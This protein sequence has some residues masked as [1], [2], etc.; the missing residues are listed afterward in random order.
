MRMHD[1]IGSRI[2]Y[3][4][5]KADSGTDYKA[6]AKYYGDK[7]CVVD[8]GDTGANINPLQIILDTQTMGNSAYAYSKAYDRH[9]GPFY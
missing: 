2:I 3:V 8:I 1:M 4:T 5:P 9:K 6:V 7:A